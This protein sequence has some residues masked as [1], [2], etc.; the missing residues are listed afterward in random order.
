MEIAARFNALELP[1]RLTGVSCHAHLVRRIDDRRTR[2]LPWTRVSRLEPSSAYFLKHLVKI[3]SWSRNGPFPPAPSTQ[4]EPLL[5]V[6]TEATLS[7]GIREAVS[8][9]KVEFEDKFE[10]GWR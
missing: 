7:F 3:L 2:I 5:F 1:S 9:Q 8:R 6:M 4:Y 10:R